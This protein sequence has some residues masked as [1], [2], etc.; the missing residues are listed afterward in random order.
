MLNSFINHYTF[1]SKIGEGAF[2]EVFKVK[3]KST[4]EYFAAKCLTKQ[5]QSIQEVNEYGEL[6]ILQKLQF[7]PNVTH[8]IDYVYE[9]NC[10]RLTLIFNLM[11]MSLYDFIKDRKKKLSET[12]CKNYLFQLGHGLFYLHHN[13][14]FHRDIKPENCLI[15]IDPELART[16]PLKA[17]L[18]QIG[19]LGSSTFTSYPQ[20]RTDYISTRWYRS[21]ECLLTGGFYGSKMDIWALGCCFYEMFTLNPL[22]PGTDEIDQLDKIHCI[23]GTPS[24][25]VLDKFK[26]GIYDYQFQK[27]NPVNMHTYVPMLSMYGVDIL[28]KTLVYNPENRISA[29]KL[30]EH[31]Y[32]DDLKSK[33]SSDTITTRLLFSKSDS[34]STALRSSYTLVSPRKNNGKLS[35]SSS[36]MSSSSNKSSPKSQIE[37]IQQ[38]LNYQLERNWNNPL[39]SLRRNMIGNIKSSV[40]K[41][42]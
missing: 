25:C 10:S 2:S 23:L 27:R 8:L 35:S 30:L 5:F 19:D 26:N 32:F 38:Q 40:T 20:P 14:I 34:D 24:K 33:I 37:A 29:K 42:G 13:G 39:S 18:V 21:P 9:S 17:E 3:K 12:R 1:E 16:N 11:E 28:K 36:V 6:K 4:R 41:I 31:V 7:H 15:R 22:F